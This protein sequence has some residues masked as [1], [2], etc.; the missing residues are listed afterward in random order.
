MPVAVE[1]VASVTEIKPEPA[2][3]TWSRMLAA[4]VLAPLAAIASLPRKGAEALLNFSTRVFR[5]GLFNI[6]RI[7]EVDV[8]SLIGA[9]HAARLSEESDLDPGDLAQGEQLART[10]SVM[11]EPWTVHWLERVV[12]PG[13]VLYDVGANVGAYSL[14][15]AISHDREVKVFAFEPSFVTYAALCRNILENECDKC[16]TPMPVALTEQRGSTVFKY[17]SLVSGAIEHAVGGALA[18]YQGV[19][20]EKAGLSAADARYPSRF[21]HSGFP[22]RP[23]RPYQ[24]R[25]RRRGAPGS[26][27][28]GSDARW[29]RGEDRA[30]RCA[31]RKGERARHGLFKGLGFGVAAKF[32]GADGAPGFHAVFARDTASVGEAMANCKIPESLR[33]QYLAEQQDDDGELP[34]RGA[35]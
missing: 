7:R 8:T 21:S 34:R 4:L 29:R 10:R 12:A 23:A 6:A 24:A 35:A 17:R 19:Q 30:D 27:R 9:P 33:Q 20:G 22:A 16:I 31:R 14:V 11:S 32:N 15:A 26:A 5:F 2:R 13:E 3:M 18:L 28:R 25:C 1:A